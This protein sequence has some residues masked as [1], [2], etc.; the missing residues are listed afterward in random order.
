[1]IGLFKITDKRD[2][3]SYVLAESQMEK[4][5]KG[6]FYIPP[7]YRESCSNIANGDVIFGVL[8]DQSGF[9]AILYKVDDNITDGSSITF[10]KDL[11]V[12]GD[13]SVKGNVDVSKNITADGNVEC[14]DMNANGTITGNNMNT[15]I[16]LTAEHV[17]AIVAAAT[18]GEPALLEAVQVIMKKL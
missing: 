17:A 14:T 12:N 1:M 2:G 13:E 3:E 7:I 4:A 8:D 11:V 15:T 16:M 18:S 6:K 10:T 5:F 9:G